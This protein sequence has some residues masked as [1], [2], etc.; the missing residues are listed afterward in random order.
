MAMFNVTR[1]KLLR[2]HQCIKIDGDVHNI[3]IAD[4]QYC[5]Q[6]LLSERRR[7]GPVGVTLTLLHPTEQPR[8]PI[9]TLSNSGVIFTV[10][11]C[12]QGYL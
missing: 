1:V 10:W 9:G 8:A 4:A 11:Q 2:F 3:I 12:K 7:L 5:L 6:V